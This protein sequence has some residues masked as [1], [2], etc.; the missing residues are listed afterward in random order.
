M[1]SATEHPNPQTMSPY[2]TLKKHH[3]PCNIHKCN[4]APFDDPEQPKM[5]PF[6]KRHTL[7][8]SGRGAGVDSTAADACEHPALVCLTVHGLLLA[9]VTL[10]LMFMGVAATATENACSRRELR[11]SCLG[12]AG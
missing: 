8:A 5:T 7:W 4:S 12:E 11:F 2:R 6:T 10:Y 1:I 3:R 9:T